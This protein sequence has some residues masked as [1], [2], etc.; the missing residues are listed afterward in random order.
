MCAS[1][2]DIVLEEKSTSADNRANG[3]LSSWTMMVLDEVLKY[4]HTC[5][6]HK[7]YVMHMNKGNSFGAK[8]YKSLAVLN[9]IE[10]FKLVCLSTAKGHTVPNLLAETSRRYSEHDL[11]REQNSLHETDMLSIN[12]MDGQKEVVD[13]DVELSEDESSHSYS[14][15]HECSVKAT[16]FKA[17]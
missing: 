9:V 11:T 13:D 3:L 5:G 6:V 12:E 17:E 2:I 8:A 15:I 4:K 10:L 1:K 16:I 14:T 7:S